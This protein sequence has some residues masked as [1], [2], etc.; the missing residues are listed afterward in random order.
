ML[1]VC[2]GGG[3][4]VLAWLIIISAIAVWIAGTVLIVRS[5]RDKK[6]KRLLIALLIGSIVLGPALVAA[7]YHGYFGD[8]SSTGK[9][10]LLLLVPGAIGAG[11][12]VASGAAHGFRAFVASTWGAVFL[13]GFGAVS[14]IAALAIGNGCLN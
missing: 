3:S 12:A 1:A 14:I 5:A 2:G 10:A 13:L 11:I 7:Y 8:D 6:E 9:V 4:E